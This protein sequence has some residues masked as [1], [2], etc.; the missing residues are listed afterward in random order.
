MSKAVQTILVITALFTFTACLSYEEKSRDLD[1]E[2][3]VY[4]GAVH[5]YTGVFATQAVEVE[6]A[7]DL[8]VAHINNAGGIIGKKV[9]LIK[10]DTG[11]QPDICA[12]YARDLTQDEGI[13]YIFGAIESACTN[14]ILDVTVP[15]GVLTVTGN[16]FASVLSTGRDN[17]KAVILSPTVSA[18]DEET[19]VDTAET[20]TPDSDN[21]TVLQNM[22]YRTSPNNGKLMQS[23][24]SKILLDGN[25]SLTIIAGDNMLNSSSADDM[26][27]Y[28]SALDCGGTRCKVNLRYN[29]SADMNPE[30]YDFS[31][32]IQGILT[33]NSDAIFFSG[34]PDDGVG[35][36]RAAVDAGFTG[37]PYISAEMGHASIGGF[38]EPLTAAAVE[39]VD[40]P[41]SSGASYEYF[42]QQYEG[43]YGIPLTENRLSEQTYDMLIILALAIHKA[44]PNGTSA[45]A[46]AAVWQVANPPGE[47]VFADEFAKAKQLIDEG[48]DIDYMGAS[49]SCDFNSVGDVPVN[50]I[51][52]GYDNKGKSV[53][54]Y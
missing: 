6:H 28:F 32:D 34:Y 23:L 18:P 17:R 15:A 50:E 40:V 49:G 20:D 45:D 13:N 22:F 30:T 11:A 5:S 33:A 2:T 29:Y 21:G 53:E 42:Q 27:R 38:I 9:A 25:K 7:E 4:I 46:A 12:Q 51:F 47:L 3:T 48:K 14:A 1:K 43:T 39:W 16:P 31:T 36:L 8:A 24:A 44:G 52:M 19:D 26:Q 35:F 41:P 10:M 54:K 37:S